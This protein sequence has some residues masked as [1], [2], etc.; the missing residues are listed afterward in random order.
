[1]VMKGLHMQPRF[2]AMQ[3]DSN[4]IQSGKLQEMDERPVPTTQESQV[5]IRSTC[6]RTGLQLI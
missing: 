4:D 5:K 6:S 1:M 3:F 2:V